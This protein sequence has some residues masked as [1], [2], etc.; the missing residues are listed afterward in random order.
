MSRSVSS[1]APTTSWVACPDGAAGA[2]VGELVYPGHRV[3]DVLLE[4]LHVAELVHVQLGGGLDVDREPGAETVSGL[5][6]LV[7]GAGHHFHVDVSLESVLVTDGVHHL[8]QALGGLRAISGDAGAEEES[9]D[10]LP[11]VKLHECSGELVHLEGVALSGDPVA[12]GTVRA[13]HLAEV[14]EHY[15]HEVDKLAVGHGRAI[16]AVGGVLLGGRVRSASVAT[17]FGWRQDVVGG[18]SAEYP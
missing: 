12:V 11:S 10:G 9:A 18:H 15:A 2:L 6:V 4:V 17:P 8:D 3:E 14:G 5:D 16:D 7:L 1:A 13:V